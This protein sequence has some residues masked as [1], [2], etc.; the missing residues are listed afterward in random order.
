MMFFKKFVEQHRVDLVV[1]HGL[2]FSFFVA[3]H[4]VRIYLSYFLGDQ[5]KAGRPFFVAL[6]VEGYRLERQNGF[7]GLIHWLNVAF[8][9]PRRCNRGQLSSGIDSYS[10]HRGRVTR[11][12]ANTANVTGRGSWRVRQIGADADRIVLKGKTSHVRTDT[13]I[14]TA[15]NGRP[16]LP[17]QC[18][19]AVS[20]VVKLQRSKT[21]RCV[22]DACAVGEKGERS[23]GRVI[24]ARGIAIERERSHGC[25]V[26]TVVVYKCSRA[27]GRVV[28]ASGI[29]QKRCRA[30]GR[31]VNSF[32]RTLVSHVE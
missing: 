8:E 10:S 25:V 19:I 20:V 3:H 26:A 2:R 32:K 12:V 31:I 27:D 6:V 21:H 24:G 18:R 28:E 4:Q 1:A 11:L 9:T 13:D 29:K 17:A 16:G 22:V 23:V 5:T 7:A 30:D 14:V 15:G